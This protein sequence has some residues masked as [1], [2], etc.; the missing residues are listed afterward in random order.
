ME[1]SG[2][3]RTAE[4]RELDAELSSPCG[5]PRSTKFLKGEKVWIPDPSG[6]GRLPAT[7]V[8]EGSPREGIEVDGVRQDV[9]WVLCGDERYRQGPPRMVISSELRPRLNMRERAQGL[10]LENSARY[11]M[12]EL[13]ERAGAE[14]EASAL[15]AALRSRDFVAA[16][17][18]DAVAVAQA[19]ERL[20]A[21]RLMANVVYAMNLATA[22]RLECG[23]D[24]R[25]GVPLDWVEHSDGDLSTVDGNGTRWA[26]FSPGPGGGEWGV[27]IDLFL[28]DWWAGTKDLAK[29]LAEE[30]SAR[31]GFR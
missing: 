22:L 30:I 21:S 5:S 14:A 23:A 19:L 6:E 20:A 27:G 18:Q 12:P 13:L 2:D 31:P 15:R 4:E 25:R 10:I 1:D 26:L 7:F 16:L 3:K 9:A 8:E 24:A 28:P 11:D 17:G 29:A